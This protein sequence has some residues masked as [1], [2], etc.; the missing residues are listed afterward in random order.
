MG[1]KVNKKM[2]LCNCEWMY[3]MIQSQAQTD[4]QKEGEERPLEGS[5]WYLSRDLNV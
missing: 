3:Q 1:E 5:E 4:T 2:N